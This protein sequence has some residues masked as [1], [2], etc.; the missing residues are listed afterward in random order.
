MKMPEANEKVEI[1]SKE[2]EDI[3]KSKMEVLQVKSTKTKHVIDRLNI[4]MDEMEE[5][6]CEREDRTTEITQSEQQR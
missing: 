3:K 1:L 5:R 6:I 2:T 4:K